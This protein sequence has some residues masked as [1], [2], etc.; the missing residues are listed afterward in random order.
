MCEGVSKLQ[1]TSGVSTAAEVRIALVPDAA[2]LR[3]RQ[4]WLDDF[5]ALLRRRQ[6]YAQ[7]SLQQTR[8]NMAM[9]IS[10]KL[11]LDAYLNPLQ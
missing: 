11:K 2:R 7:V 1:I 3:G 5:P 6:S 9:S 8:G 4:V 10:S